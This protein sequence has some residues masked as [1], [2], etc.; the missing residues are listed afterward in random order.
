MSSDAADTHH[1]LLS[2]VWMYGSDLSEV[3]AS[4]KG[5]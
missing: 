2:G 5:E 4:V 1:V 3:L